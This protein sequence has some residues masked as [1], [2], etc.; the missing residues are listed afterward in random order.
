M[1]GKQGK[2][3][4]AGGSGLV[5]NVRE[6]R[7]HRVLT[8]RGAFGNLLVGEARYDCAKYVDFPAGEPEGL[9]PPPRS[10]DLAQ[11]WHGL[12]ELL[13]PQPEVARH[14]ARDAL[15]KYF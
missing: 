8:D 4:A 7:L 12:R 10:L 14:D 1:S 11:A 6:V 13:R 2:L 3:D 9:G 15:E 5:E